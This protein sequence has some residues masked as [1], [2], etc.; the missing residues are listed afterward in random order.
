MITEH[1]RNDRCDRLAVIQHEFK[2]TFSE[3]M[4]QWVCHR[5]DSHA[6]KMSNGELPPVRKLYR[7]NVTWTNSETVEANGDTIDHHV[8]LVI[9]E[10][11]AVG[12]NRF[13]ERI[14]NCDVSPVSGSDH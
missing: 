8:Q 6:R 10:R 14:V 9:G 11:V 3:N 1:R 5:T 2:F 4:H 7:N 13:V 12:R